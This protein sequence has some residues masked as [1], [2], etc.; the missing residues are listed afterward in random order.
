MGGSIKKFRWVMPVL[1]ADANLKVRYRGY[2][3]SP[4]RPADRPEFPVLS[5]LELQVITASPSGPRFAGEMIKL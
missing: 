3:D 1:A 5:R 2:S 4:R